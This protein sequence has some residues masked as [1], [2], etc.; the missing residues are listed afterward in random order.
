M[1]PTTVTIPQ[2]HPTTPRVVGPVR[3]YTKFRWAD[4]WSEKDDLFCE[5]AVWTAAPSIGT[6]TIH[7][8]YGRICP[9]FETAF[10]EIFRLVNQNRLYVRVEVPCDVDE[11]TSLRYWFGIIEVDEDIL[12]GEVYD[13]LTDT[14][15][16]TGEQTFTAYGL[17]HML[18]RQ[19]VNHAWYDSDGAGDIK[20]IPRA[21]IF[22]REGKPNRSPDE[23]GG[24]YHFARTLDDAEFWTTRDIVKYLLRYHG[25]QDASDERKIKFEL[26]EASAMINAVPD[27]DRPTLDPT[28]RSTYSLLCSLIPRQ[29]LV[30]FRLAVELVLGEE[31]E[32]DEYRVKVKPFSF[33]DTAIPTIAGQGDIP[34]NTVEKLILCSRDPSGECEVKTTTA[35]QYDQVIARGARRRSVFTV[36]YNDNTIEKGWTDA[37]EEEY[38]KGASEVD[39]YD[40]ASLDD[41]RRK[42]QELRA[43][44][45]LRDVFSRFTIPETW[46]QKV[47]NGLGAGDE[48]PV[49][50]DDEDPPGAVDQ[51]VPELFVEK[52]LPLIDGVDYSADKIEEETFDEEDKKTEAPPLVLWKEPASG[53]YCNVERMSSD[54]PLLDEKEEWNWSASVTVPDEYR[55]V[56]LNVSG[57]PQHVVDHTDFAPLDADEEVGQH[58]W[59][60]AL[61]TVSMQDDRHAESEYPDDDTV[62][63]TVLGDEVRRLHIEAGDKYR[64]D[65]VVPDTVV[66]VDDDGTPL[67]SEGGFVHDDR[68]ELD[69]IARIA[70][71]WYSRE[72]RVLYLAT[73]QLTHELE[74]GDMVTAIN[75]QDADSLG[76]HYFE[77]A[78]PI[79]EIRVNQS[80]GTTDAPPLPPRMR[81]ATDAGQLDAL[82]LVNPDLPP[83]D[84]GSIR[85]MSDSFSASMSAARDVMTG[86]RRSSFDPMTAAR[87][88]VDPA[89]R[90]RGAE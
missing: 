64:L 36:G 69:A 7:W 84:V 27:W 26:D 31:E 25:P 6:A 82:V 33:T 2:G 4:N 15:T 59:R 88:H 78:T 80:R 13:Q 41:Q 29:R 28:N 10:R 71:E 57:A 19:F 9:T 56:R 81:L 65:Y 66:G 45:A 43:K 42:N 14:A 24:T 35:E 73:D 44:D 52:T 39:G 55:G 48:R 53:R 22:N 12:Q 54:R 18:D 89:F 58:N 72:R 62:F 83:P 51:Y 3:V 11:P 76:G 67:R 90:D 30:S 49:F 46:N 61:F 34:A 75:D 79:T 77:I 37:Q 1:P 74:I 40:D 70:W 32:D 63:L 21:V 60:N 87:L 17:E 5:E 38:E 68:E 47:R 86:G 85:G 20:Q 50:I 23:S 16:G 8:H